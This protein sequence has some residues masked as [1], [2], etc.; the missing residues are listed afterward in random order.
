MLKVAL[1]WH[2]ANSENLGVGALT[3]SNIA[4]VE[5]V[6]AE[7]NIP[8]EFVIMCWR[9]A[10]AMQI[11][12]SNVSV[13]QMRAR[14]LVSPS[15]LYGELRKCDVVLD[16]SAGDSFADIYGSRRFIFNIISKL[17]V[18]AARRPLIMSPQTVGPFKQ[19]WAAT[20]AGY[21]MRW[22]DTVVT[23]DGLSTEYVS[24]FNLTNTVEA[25]DVAFRLPFERQV[26]QKGSRKNIGINVSGWL[27]ADGQKVD[28]MVQ[29][30]S[31]YPQFIRKLI[32]H[33]LE[34][35]DCT[36]HLV[37]H[38]IG[39]SPQ[40]DYRASEQ[41]GKEFPDVVVAPRF[42]NP[43]IAKGYIS[44]LDFFCGSRMHAC[45][46]AFSSGV[47]VIPIAYSRKFAGLFGSL[48]YHESTDLLTQDGDEIIT[49]VSAGFDHLDDLKKKVVEGQRNAESKLK[50]YEDV[51]RRT[52]LRID[53]T[54]A[55]R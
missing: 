11:H 2:S 46:A 25:T 18:F 32:R 10:D 50:R 7:L 54:K 51:V 23:R 38:V 36:I 35:G 21:L 48:G 1:L 45:I 14:D 15:R 6:A 47:P 9:D 17:A 12:Q 53:N 16:I 19:A 28:N 26:P 41:L 39:N 34:R 40:D 42:A 30:K 55:T 20:V 27:F 24:R 4:I 31:D 37:G 49:R 5:K 13:F 52:L 22:S 43:S 33:F 8:V 3:V 44:K 29:L